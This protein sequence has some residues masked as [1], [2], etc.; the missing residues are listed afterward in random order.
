MLIKDT[1]LSYDNIHCP[2]TDIYEK[3]KNRERESW[4]GEEKKLT[5]INGEHYFKLQ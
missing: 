3:V 2:A 1:V 4:C 5:F